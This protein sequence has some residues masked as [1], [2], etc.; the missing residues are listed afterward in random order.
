MKNHVFILSIVGI[1]S[2][3]GI[4]FCFGCQPKKNMVSNKEVATSLKKSFDAKATIKMKDLVLTADIN[5]TA[6]GCATI[7]ISEPKSLK[8]MKFEYDGKDVKIGYKGLSVKLDENSKLVSSLVAIIV[9]SIDKAASE[10]GVSVKV[11]GKVLVVSGE[12]ESG[13][14]AITIDRESGSIASINLPELDFECHFDDFLV[15]Q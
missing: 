3:F 12:S 1:V 2:V 9:N 4:L 5:K 15:K 14:F 8:D 13:K 7:K 11:E 10:S 6:V